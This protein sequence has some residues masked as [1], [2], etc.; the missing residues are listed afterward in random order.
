VAKA[1]EKLQRQSNF[2]SLWVDGGDGSLFTLNNQTSPDGTSTAS[3]I[4]LAGDSSV[5][6]RN[7]LPDFG[8]RVS[9]ISGQAT[10]VQ[11][12]ARFTDGV[13]QQY[14]R[15]AIAAAIAKAVQS[16]PTAFGVVLAASAATAAISA[17]LNRPVTANTFFCES[18]SLF[19]VCCGLNCTAAVDT[20]TA[21][22]KHKEMTTISVLLMLS[23]L[24][25]ITCQPP[26]DIG[27]RDEEIK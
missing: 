13:V 27:L 20:I 7:I 11:G 10:F 23:L 6:Q 8:I 26:L 21:H 24:L 4:A 25:D 5:L 16:S 17:L 1:E 3:P 12:L 22:T 2:Q 9:V 18:N 14:G 19:A 15:Q